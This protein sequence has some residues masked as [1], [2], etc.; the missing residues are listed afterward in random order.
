MG[1]C[2]LFQFLACNC[3]EEGS[4]S[5]TC[6]DNGVCSCK[7]NIINDKCDVCDNGYFNFPTCE[8]KQI[9]CT[10]YILCNFHKT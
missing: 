3:T 7:A 9:P 2:L 5:T 10:Y 4:N 1:L 8:G 6:D